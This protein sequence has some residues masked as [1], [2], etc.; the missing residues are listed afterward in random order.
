MRDDDVVLLDVLLEPGVCT[1]RFSEDLG[2]VLDVLEVG[3]R[4]RAELTP[5]ERA[6][7]RAALPHTSSLD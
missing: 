3:P 1:R 5:P 2:A 4:V 7:E 6:R